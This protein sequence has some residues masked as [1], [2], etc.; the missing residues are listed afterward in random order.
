M[1]L[2][3]AF[4]EFVKGS[5][6][7]NTLVSGRVYE[8]IMPQKEVYPAIV[9]QIVGGDRPSYSLDGANGQVENRLQVTCYATSGILRRALADTFRKAIDG[10]RGQWGGT[11][12]QSVFIDEEGSAFEPSTGNE[13][14]RSWGWRFDL[15]ISHVEVVPRF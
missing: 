10:Y 11:E 14:A 12:I 4:V 9:Y 7:L 3:A 15:L 1:S 2:E 6:P 13:A 5:E 8:E